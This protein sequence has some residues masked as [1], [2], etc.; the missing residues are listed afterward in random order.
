VNTFDVAIIGGGLIGASIAFE[1]AA[2][3]LRVVLLDCQQPGREASWA[4]AGMI[5]PAPDSPADV[6]LVPLAQQSLGLYPA[7]IAAVEEASGQSTGY[8]REGTLEIFSAPDG[9]AERDQ[10]AAEHQ[11]LGLAAEPLSVDATRKLGLSLGPTARAAL[12]LPR[13]G[14]V[15]PRRLMDAVLAAAS[16]RGVMIY[17]DSRVTSLLHDR[18]RSTGVVCR[19][20]KIAARHVVLAAGCFSARIG[21]ERAPGNAPE[22]AGENDF[23]ARYAP[24]RPVRGQMLELR[25]AGQTPRQVIR[26]RRGYLVPRRDGR[27]VAGS[28]LEEAGFNK[29]VTP[30]GTRQ[31]LD[32]ALELL[33]ELGGAQILD[34]W[35]G[36]RPG[37]PDH[38]PILGP[39][40]MEGLLVATGHYRNGILLAPVTAKLIREWITD[41]QASLEVRAFSPLRFGNRRMNARSAL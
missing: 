4:A 20:E 37:T 30:A 7:F 17:P 13:E 8:A 41:G 14:T 25:P 21:H 35:A 11:R 36:L 9:E 2:V 31:I 5:S 18:D 39:T 19:G 29:Q 26:S 15:E 28:T 34:S 1:L 12:W 32:A 24:T 3:G 33:P 40:D 16:H 38:L 27:M 23:V 6:P 10:M 22:I